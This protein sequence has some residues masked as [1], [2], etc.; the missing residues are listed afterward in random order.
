MVEQCGAQLSRINGGLFCPI[1]KCCWTP[2][3][4]RRA[5]FHLNQISCKKELG[6]SAQW[7]AW[8]EN[9]HNKEHTLRPTWPKVSQFLR[10]TS[11]PTSV[12]SH[13]D[14]F[15]ADNL[16]VLST[17]PEEFKKNKPKNLTAQHKVAMYIHYNKS[18]IKSDN[19]WYIKE[20]LK[21]PHGKW[22]PEQVAIALRAQRSQAW[23]KVLVGMGRGDGP[24][25]TQSDNRQISPR[26]WLQSVGFMQ[27]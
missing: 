11:V 21:S 18:E 5:V 15:R 7:K 25:K 1:K 17:T 27:G 23:S 6:T 14:Q 4:S 22:T 3:C 26:W 16:F 2:C 24:Y 12:V 8:Q 10:T 20:I 13:L 19:K 9:S